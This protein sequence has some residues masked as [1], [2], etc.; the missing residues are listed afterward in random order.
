MRVLII[1]G[2]RQGRNIA[3]R[4]LAKD[5][6]RLV[7]RAAEHQIVFI[8]EDED[9]CDELEQRYHVPIFQG[10]GTKTELLRQ[11]GADNVDVAIAASNDDSRNVIAAL[12]ARRL[13]IA[14]VI[15][16]VQDTDYISL[17]E[18]NGVVA[19]SAPQATAV[20]VENYLDRPGVSE[21]FEIGPGVASLVGVI[22]PDG[23]RVVGKQ[24]RDIDI[25]RECVVAAIIR[26]KQFAVPRGD[27]EILAGDH[28]VFV[29]PA[30][31]IKSA[32]DRFLLKNVAS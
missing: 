1:S 3:D 13:G 26:G 8:E 10:D 30:S 29:G 28:V 31:A 2:D 23:A 17:L 24:I 16:L 14:Q 5:E 15:A 18:E 7:F 6:Y 4:L 20:M 9:I 11:V 32:Q 27:T 22:V 21:L 25:P 19:M 12:Q